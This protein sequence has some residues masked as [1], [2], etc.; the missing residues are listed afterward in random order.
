MKKIVS[1]FGILVLSVLLAQVPA[2]AQMKLGFK[3]TG[4]LGYYGAGDLNAG[5]QGWSDAFRAIY[6]TYEASGGYSPV[7][8]GMDF[9]GEFL[10]QFNPKLALGLGVGY[11][12]ASRSSSLT[13]SSSGSSVADTW[14]P[15]ISAVPVTL[16]VHYYIPLAGKL[17]LSLDAGVGYYFGTCTDSQHIVFIIEID[18]TYNATASGIGFHGGLGLEI[19][20]APAVSIVFEAR[21]R[22]ASLGSFKGT[23]KSNSSETTGDVWIEEVTLDKKY[24]L[25]DIWEDTPTGDNPRLAKL[26]FSGFSFAAGFLFRFG[27]GR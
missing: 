23:I 16:N 22:Y 26:D 24:T 15:K 21:G 1:L 10:L 3:L 7:H 12:Q 13:F 14:S 17:R 9:G 5:L 19:P 25:I 11:I 6:N 20:V 27:G 4:G 2:Q 8:W 18:R